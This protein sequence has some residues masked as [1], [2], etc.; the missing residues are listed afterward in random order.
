MDLIQLINI[1]CKFIITINRFLFKRLAQCLVYILHTQ[2]FPRFQFY[3]IGRGCNYTFCAITSAMVSTYGTTV[4]M[5]QNTLHRNHL[6]NYTFT[7]ELWE[8]SGKDTKTFSSFYCTNQVFCFQGEQVKL[9][10]HHQCGTLNIHKLA[11]TFQYIQ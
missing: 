1:I 3:P 8:S 9:K 6:E 10:N 7:T 4:K 2:P 11:S 5:L